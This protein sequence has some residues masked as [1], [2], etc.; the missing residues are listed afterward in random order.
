[1]KG[2]KARAEKC[3]TQIKLCGERLDQPSTLQ[4]LQLVGKSF[5]N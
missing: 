5:K 1:M 3:F 2:D 4:I